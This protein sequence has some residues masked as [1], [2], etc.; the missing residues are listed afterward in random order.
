VT[1]KERKALRRRLKALTPMARQALLKVLLLP[2][3]ERAALIADLERP[4][5]SGSGAELLID[6][7]KDSTLREMLVELLQERTT[8]G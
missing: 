7:E 6:C 1:F 8:S 4:P 3:A 5:S 2:D